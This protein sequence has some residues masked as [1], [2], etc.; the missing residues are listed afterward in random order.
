VDA[1]ERSSEENRYR[2]GFALARGEA[3]GRG[4][5]FSTCTGVRPWECPSLQ[6]PRDGQLR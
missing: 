4:V 5:V 2:S 3:V 6:L 1:A